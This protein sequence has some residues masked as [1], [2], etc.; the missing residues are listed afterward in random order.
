MKVVPSTPF[1]ARGCSVTGRTADVD[2]FVQVNSPVDGA[3]LHISATAVKIMGNEFGMIP[4]DEAVDLRFKLHATEKENAELRQT[5]R[6][7][8]LLESELVEARETIRES[9]DILAIFAALADQGY[10]ASKAKALLSAIETFENNLGDAKETVAELDD[11]LAR[12]ASLAR[13]GRKVPA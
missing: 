6:D 7:Q 12:I 11:A 2:G 5:I 10:T 13:G 9:E 1:G 3:R 8:E 4:R